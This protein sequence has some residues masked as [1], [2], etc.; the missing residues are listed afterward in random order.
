MKKFLLIWALFIILCCSSV[1]GAQEHILTPGD[2][3][4]LYVVGQTSENATTEYL[5]LK[6]GSINLPLIGRVNTTGLTINALAETVQQKLGEY[7]VKPQ[8]V[9]NIIALGTTR[10]Y[11]LGE[12]KTPGLY[13]F[14]KS[15]TVID[16]ISAAG[17]FNRKSKATNIFLVRN[18]DEN[19][20]EHVNIERYLK[21]G[22]M[23][24][25]KVL[26]EGD[27]LFFTSN[28]AINFSKDIL[29]FINATYYIHRV[30]ED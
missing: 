5:I 15:H 9:A 13:E 7:L 2:K 17:G 16:A 25:N 6:D 4:Q 27:C 28:H 18:C 24:E 21:Y 29:P 12:I 23:S 1:C 11:V 3:I 10:I 22:D 20:I 8:V 19:T 30:M 26:N 14:T